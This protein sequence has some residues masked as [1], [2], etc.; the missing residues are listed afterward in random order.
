MKFILMKTTL[1]LQH[2][3]KGLNKKSIIE[4]LY[5]TKN[6]W[7]VVV[8]PD[9]DFVTVEYLDIHALNNVKRDL[10]ELGYR[11]LNDTHHLDPNQTP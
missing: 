8:N 5:T 11:I 3:S 7:N 1:E 9:K 4:K 2:S 6:I 10:D